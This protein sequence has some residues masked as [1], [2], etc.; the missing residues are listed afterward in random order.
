M[1]DLSPSAPVNS[2]PTGMPARANGA[3]SDPPPRRV[4]I[5]RWP[6]AAKYRVK[7]R[8]I[9]AEPGGGAALPSPDPSYTKGTKFF[10][11]TMSKFR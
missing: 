3:W 7:T 1:P 11:P 6:R 5:T 2:P 4:G 10:E 9:S 8:S